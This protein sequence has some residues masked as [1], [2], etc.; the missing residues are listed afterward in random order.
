MK[1]KIQIPGDYEV[2]FSNVVKEIAIGDGMF[3]PNNEEHY[4]K[5]G[6]SAV[7]VIKESL[8]AA[9][10]HETDIHSILDYACGY[11]RVLRWLKVAFPM[12]DIRGVDADPKAVAGAATVTGVLVK[13]LDIKLE[14]KLDNRF[15]LIWVG[16]LF[17]HLPLEE[18][19]RVLRYLKKHLNKNALLVFTTHGHIVERRIKTRERSYNLD[20][21]N[22]QVLI[23]SFDKDGYGFSNYSW[24]ENYGIS[25]SRTSKICLLIENCGMQPIF[26]KER[27]WDNHQDVFACRLVEGS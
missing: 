26:F 14:N 11:G 9:K 17:T 8:A 4:F 1:E 10:I 16:S 2:L 18:V 20:D 25:I 23:K 13:H 21:H 6:A 7:S 12:A 24:R 5:V 19:A 3:K 15:D 27:G 22:I